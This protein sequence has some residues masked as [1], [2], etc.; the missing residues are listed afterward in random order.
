M[1]KLILNLM[2]LNWSIYLTNAPIIGFKPSC[3]FISKLKC[4]LPSNVLWCLV[5]NATPM[6]CP[7]LALGLDANWIVVGLI[8]LKIDT[9]S[10][11]VSSAPPGFTTCQHAG[12]ASS[13]S[14][15]NSLIYAMLVYS[16]SFMVCSSIDFML[17]LT[18]LI[19]EFEIFIMVSPKPKTSF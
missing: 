2:W 8:C 3:D 15:S 10:S 16:N 17:N 19:I 9:P 14:D 5:I 18:L 6:S 4:R 13:V 1:I 7:S 11:D 12:A